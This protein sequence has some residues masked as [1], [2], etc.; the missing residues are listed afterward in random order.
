MDN[1]TLLPVIVCTFGTPIS[2]FTIKSMLENIKRDA[3]SLQ[4]TMEPG[5]LG[6][7]IIEQHPRPCTNPPQIARQNTSRSRPCLVATSLSGRHV[8]MMPSPTLAHEQ[9]VD[10]LPRHASSP[11]RMV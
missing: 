8:G 9:S 5:D 3:S 7:E 6:P 2:F 10:T 1:Y 11:G 4:G